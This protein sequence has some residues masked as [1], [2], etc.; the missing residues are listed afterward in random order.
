MVKRLSFLG[1]Y[2]SLCC[3][4]PVPVVILD[5]ALPGQ[6][7]KTTESLRQRSRDAGESPGIDQSVPLDDPKSLKAADL[8]AAFGPVRAVY[9]A[10]G[11]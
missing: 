7:P 6:D 1:C 3:H 8:S 11:D 9:R 2:C 10:S 4:L 5:D